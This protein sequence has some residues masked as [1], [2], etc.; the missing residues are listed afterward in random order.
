MFSKKL[1]LQEQSFD[2]KFSSDS[3][4]R[5]QSKKYV[6]TKN[7]QL[8]DIISTINKLT[9]IEKVTQDNL[10]EEERKALEEMRILCESSLVLKKADK[11]NT[12]VLMD[13]QDY[14]Q[15]LVLK[16]HLLTSTYETARDD[17]NHQVY[18]DLVKLCDKHQNCI[19]ASERKVI[20]KEDWSESQFYI[21]PKIHKCQTILDQIPSSSEEYL[22]IPFPS[23][24]KGRPICGDVNWVTQGLSRLTNRILKPLVLHQRR[25]SFPTKV[26]KIHST[27]CKGD[28]L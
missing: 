16:G 25:V 20:L 1:A 22:Q 17:A 2:I 24:L 6:T 8:E 5:P 3:L 11:S 9:P 10:D 27:K 26:S 28:M 19:T 7:K 21:L 15:T 14:E 12:L 18:K 4:I 13:K 23:D